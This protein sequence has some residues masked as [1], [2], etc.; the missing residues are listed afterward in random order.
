MGTPEIVV[1]RACP[2]SSRFTPVGAP[3]GRSGDFSSV[4]AS[5]FSAH[6]FSASEGCRPSNT[7]AIGLSATCGFGGF[8]SIRT[9]V[10]CLDDR[11]VRAEEQGGNTRS[12]RPVG[13]LQDAPV[14]LSGAGSSRSELRAQS[15]DPYGWHGIP[16]LEGDLLRWYGAVLMR[17]GSR[18]VIG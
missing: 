4:G 2:C 18:Q 6:F 5:V 16:L 10:S 11:E 14:I 8:F 3:I 15:K 1:K 9:P 17:R 13:Q 12:E 7:S